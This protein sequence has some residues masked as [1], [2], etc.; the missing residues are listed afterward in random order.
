MS[1][2]SVTPPEDVHPHRGASSPEAVYMRGLIDGM[3]RARLEAEAQQPPP[4]GHGGLA[5][6]SWWL[7]FM[8]G[9]VTVLIT[10][11]TTLILTR[12]DQV[13]ER[14]DDMHELARAICL[15]DVEL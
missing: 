12:V 10:A 4:D 1:L 5:T 3:E 14:Y 11:A 15:A 7:A 9:L 8:A 13:A 6:P 2:H